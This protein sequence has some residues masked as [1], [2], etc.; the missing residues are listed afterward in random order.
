MGPLRDLPTSYHLP[1]TSQQNAATLSL[2]QPIFEFSRPHIELREK[3][4][5]GRVMRARG[6]N[7]AFATLSSFS[8]ICN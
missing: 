5:A 3:A 7:H 6:L 2:Q 1:D 4:E 8:T